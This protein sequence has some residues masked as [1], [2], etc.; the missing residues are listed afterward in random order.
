[1]RSCKL[2][3]LGTG[4]SLHDVKTLIQEHPVIGAHFG[5]FLVIKNPCVALLINHPNPVDKNGLMK[6]ALQAKQPTF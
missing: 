6:N 4:G 2:E 3:R 1:M 5:G